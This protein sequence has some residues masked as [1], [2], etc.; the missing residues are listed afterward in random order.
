MKSHPHI[1][2]VWGVVLERGWLH[3]ASERVQISVNRFEEASMPTISESRDRPHCGPSEPDE[4]SRYPGSSLRIKELSE[5]VEGKSCLLEC[6]GEVNGGNKCGNKI[7][8][9]EGVVDKGNSEAGV[10]KI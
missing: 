3:S 6:M 5:V 4:S 7:G 8:E 1:V 9:S 2:Q 10:G